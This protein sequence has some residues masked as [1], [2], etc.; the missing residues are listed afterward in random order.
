MYR[1]IYHM[2][3]YILTKWIIMKRKSI[4]KKLTEILLPADLLVGGAKLLG[5]L[6]SMRLARD[7]WPP[8]V[9]S[10]K[11]LVSRGDGTGQVGVSPP[12]NRPTGVMRT[13]HGLRAG[14]RGRGNSHLPARSPAAA[15]G[16]ERGEQGTRS[17]VGARQAAMPSP[18]C[19]WPQPHPKL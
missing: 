6:K 8:L 13:P 10:G 12:V 18:T 15:A 4:H 9:S 5:N 2:C 1:K 19:L 11:Q 17:A 16:R 7:L 14:G 3:V